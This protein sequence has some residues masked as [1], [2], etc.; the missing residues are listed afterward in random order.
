MADL[1]SNEE[2]TCTIVTGATGVLGGAFVR[3][4]LN[5][6]EIAFGREILFLTGRSEEKLAA[7]KREIASSFPK[8]D[9]AYFPADLSSRE[10][11]NALFEYLETLRGG[12]VKVAR[13]VNVAGADIQKAFEKY[14]QEKLSFQCGVNFEAA[15]SFCLYAVQHAAKRAEIINISSVSGI[16]PMPYFAVYSATKGALTSFSLAL[17]REV[18]RKGI[19]VCAVL[20]GAMPTREDIKE[21]IRGQGLWGR[22]AALPPATVAKRSL[23]AAEKNKGKTIIGFYNK[24]MNFGTKLLPISLKMRFIEKRWSKISKDAF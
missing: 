23:R 1:T 14:T 19:R 13:L 16:Y 5:K 3:E 21:Q 6:E 4:L 9:V 7:L 20:P 12:G 15:A 24:L 17:R 2:K 11:R 18:K 8:A 22:L 10:E